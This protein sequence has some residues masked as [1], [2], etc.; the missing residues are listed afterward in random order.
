MGGTSRSGKRTPAHVGV[1]GR[2][3]GRAPGVQG[4]EGL[5][6]PGTRVRRL[7][8]SSQRCAPGGPGQAGPRRANEVGVRRLRVDQ[9]GEGLPR[10]HPPA[11]GPW[12]PPRRRPTRA[13][14][15]RQARGTPR[16]CRPSDERPARLAFRRRL[17]GLARP[18][19]PGGRCADPSVG[20][21]CL[22]TVPERHNCVRPEP[23][24]RAALA[25]PGPAEL[26]LAATPSGGEALWRVHTSRQVPLTGSR[27]PRR[28]RGQRQPG[29]PYFFSGLHIP[30]NGR[31]RVGRLR[32]EEHEARRA[33]RGL[34][35]ACSTRPC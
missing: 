2:R 26:G 12:Y 22:V 32:A 8:R 34:W 33:R 3:R 29:L 4:G 31:R 10:R 1:S 20:V 11:S 25:W 7:Q 28:H 30:P 18:G 23:S 21:D 15:A 17:R 14:A 13:H 6:W 27:L 35:G 19:V 16:S 5:R 24:A 9:D